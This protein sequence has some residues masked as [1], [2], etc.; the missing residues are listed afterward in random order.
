MWSRGEGINPSTWDH[1]QAQPAG[2]T[3]A[4]RGVPLHFQI[5]RKSDRGHVTK[6]L[7]PGDFEF[8]SAR[9]PEGNAHSPLQHSST[10]LRLLLHIVMN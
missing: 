1:G 10:F 4:L 5:Q 7:K 2:G 9:G 8:G 3:G 6:G